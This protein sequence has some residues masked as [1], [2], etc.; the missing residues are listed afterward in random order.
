MEL[1]R[2]SD[3]IHFNGTGY[4]MVADA[5]VQAA[6]DAFDLTPKVLQSP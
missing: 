4:E 2:A 3:G 5:A 1:I 6:I